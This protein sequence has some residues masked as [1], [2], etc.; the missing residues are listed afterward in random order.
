MTAPNEPLDAALALARAFDGAGIPGFGTSS[1]Q[2][3]RMT[4]P[5]AQ[6]C[7]STE[8]AV[9]RGKTSVFLLL[10]TA[11]VHFEAAQWQAATPK[12]RALQRAGK[13]GG[14][15]SLQS[16]LGSFAE[17]L[18]GVTVP[19]ASEPWQVLD[20]DLARR[21][22]RQ[23]CALHDVS[24]QGASAYGYDIATLDVLGHLSSVS[25]K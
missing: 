6:S 21:R 8:P 20:V 15:A 3:R 7:A 12:S 2:R 18:T 11:R 19:S 17:S 22:Q 5:A 10:A 16:T 4:E 23:W 9:Q 24:I 1:S 13:P 25:D 14:C